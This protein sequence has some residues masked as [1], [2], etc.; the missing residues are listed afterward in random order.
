MATTE[1]QPFDH[2]P[3]FHVHLS[4]HNEIRD[5]PKLHFELSMYQA[6]VLAVFMAL[7]LFLPMG[8]IAYYQ[9]GPTLTSE[10]RELR[11]RQEAIATGEFVNETEE[12]GRVAGVSDTFTT[13]E[14][15]AQSVIE[16]INIDFNDTATRYYVI[17]AIFGITSLA[18]LYYLY[19]DHKKHTARLMNEL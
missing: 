9:Y 2:E 18:I 16:Q 15:E 1:T 4:M 17:S 3:P 13:F 19:H 6:I 10:E 14:S 7:F 8:A 12:T 11:D 5:L